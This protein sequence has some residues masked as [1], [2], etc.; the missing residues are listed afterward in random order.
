M[1]PLSN[2][3]GCIVPCIIV[4]RISQEN[5]EKSKLLGISFFRFVFCYSGKCAAM[6]YTVGHTRNVKPEEHTWENPKNRR[7]DKRL[8]NSEEK[9]ADTNVLLTLYTSADGG[10]TWQE[11]FGT[12]TYAVSGENKWHVESDTITEGTSVHSGVYTFCHINCKMFNLFS[13]NFYIQK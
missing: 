13:E 9:R 3:A 2:L 5:P 10:A 7:T 1:H 4:Y 12:P 11:F 8:K 6:G